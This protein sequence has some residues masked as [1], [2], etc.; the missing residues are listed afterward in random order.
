MLSI[1][2]VVNSWIYMYNMMLH[3]TQSDPEKK[4][5]Q[6]EKVNYSSWRNENVCSHKTEQKN[7]RNNKKTATHTTNNRTKSM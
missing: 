5:K 1:L 4:S 2:S 6:D 3:Y 7:K